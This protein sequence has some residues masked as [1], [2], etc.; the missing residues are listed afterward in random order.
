[1]LKQ[2][3]I[4]ELTAIVGEGA[5]LTGHGDCCGYERDM[6]IYRG[7]ADAVLLPGR[8]EAVRAVIAYAAARK[9]PVTPRGAGTSVTG[10]VLPVAGGIVLDLSRMNRVREINRDDGYVVVEPGVI[11][12]ELN[13]AL[14]GDRF[15]PPDPGSLEVATIGG[16]ISTN[17]S[18]RSA[19]KYGTTRDYL[20]GLTAVLPSG[21]VVKTGHFTRKASTG[22]DL[23]HLFAAA[24]G[25]LGVI[26]EAVL[27]IVPRPAATAVCLAG[28]PT[29]EDAAGAAVSLVTADLSLSS[30]EL[31]DGLSM[32]DF[33]R[34][35]GRDLG[36]VK[37][38]L[39]IE[40]DGKAGDVEERIGE[41]AELCEGLGARRRYL[42]MDAAEK[43]RVWSL[44]N[45]LINSLSA[46]T[47]GARLVP[48]AEDIGVPVSRVPEAMARVKASAKAHGIPIV[49]FGHAGDGNIHATF[50]LD[51]E[52][53]DGWN[54]AEK[55]TRA[56]FG[57]ALELRG[58][59]SAEHGIGLSRA[60]FIAEELGGAHGM[61]KRIKKLFD[62]L[63]I[64][65]PGKLGF[66]EAPRDL[67]DDFAFSPRESERE[68]RVFPA[69][70]HKGKP[71]VTTEGNGEKT[72]PVHAPARC[73]ECEIC[74]T[75]CGLHGQ[76]DL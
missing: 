39:M 52:D 38:L 34:G 40:A 12:G 60:P 54:R 30:C 63:D 72:E 4:R 33:S 55:L 35:I 27:R 7:R 23:T 47:P 24:E 46:F 18:G 48:M 74:R 20:L 44:R 11:C 5:V 76:T 25:T 62:P 43:D 67:F 49:L 37:G 50:I 51:P 26:T 71:G 9:I 8:E 3:E 73:L 65:N 2:E 56:C 28:F 42:F 29:L 13:R 58:T 22:F 59:I 66:S 45:R 31:M 69:E 53:R 6:S 19:G 16:M 57:I 14:P 75:D 1:M 15:F 17:A 21:E 64:M 32:E 68:T 41:V 61:M 10:A 36:G 70:Q